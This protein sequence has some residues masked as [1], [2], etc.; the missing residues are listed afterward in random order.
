MQQFSCRT[1]NT[2][3]IAV[4]IAHLDKTIQIFI[5][6]NDNKNKFEFIYNFVRRK[7]A[8]H[9]A[10]Q[11]NGY[12]V[13]A[14]NVSTSSSSSSAYYSSAG[15]S[16][17]YFNQEKS[18]GIG[19][20]QYHNNNNVIEISQQQSCSIEEEEAA[21]DAFCGTIP[22]KVSEKWKKLF[23]GPNAIKNGRYLLWLK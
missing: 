14:P 11:A 2:T 7:M 13:N 17:N 23:S 8:H 1:T 9:Q 4:F 15:V 6:S 19:T 3:A 12:Y 18:A 21:L 10:N 20:Q 5:H 22:A 16:F